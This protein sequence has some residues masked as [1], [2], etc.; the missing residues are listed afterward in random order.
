MC[1]RQILNYLISLCPFHY[2]QLKVKNSTTAQT[3]LYAQSLPNEVLYEISRRL[4][5]PDCERLVVVSREFSHLIIP[6]INM[7]KTQVLKMLRLKNILS[8]NLNKNGKKVI[9]EKR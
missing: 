6:L 8:Y 3:P 2:S 1:L 4:S 5:W 9:V 7:Y